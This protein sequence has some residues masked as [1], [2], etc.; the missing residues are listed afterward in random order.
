MPTNKKNMEK[1]EQI[2]IKDIT[3]IIGGKVGEPMGVYLKVGGFNKLNLF[4]NIPLKHVHDILEKNMEE[5]KFKSKHQI[6]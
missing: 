2:K 1:R 5:I 3:L 6:L 4:S